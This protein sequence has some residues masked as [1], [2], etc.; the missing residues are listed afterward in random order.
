MIAY[1]ILA[2]QSAEQVM[3]LIGSIYRPGDVYAVHMDAKASPAE[4]AKLA[5]LCRQKPNIY[6]FKSRACAWGSF[7]LVRVVLD[8][9]QSLL[10]LT[11]NWSHFVLLSEQHYPLRPAP[12]IASALKRDVSYLNTSRH[13]D[14]SQGGQNDIGHR[15]KRVYHELEGVGSFGA[16]PRD[17]DL[18]HIYHASQWSV[19]SRFAAGFLVSSFRENRKSWADLE[20]SLLPDEI[21]FPTI[22]MNASDD[23]R[24]EVSGEC[25]T[26]V[27]WPH[28]TDNPDLIACTKTFEEGKKTSCLFIRKRPS[29]LS[30][31]TEF[32]IKGPETIHTNIEIVPPPDTSNYKALVPQLKQEIKFRLDHLDIMDY[33]GQ[34]YTARVQLKLRCRNWDWRVNVMVISHDGQKFRIILLAGPENNDLAEKQI[35]QYIAH[36]LKV[37]LVDIQGYY[38]VD[39][40][41][42]FDDLV[43]LSSDPQREDFDR[44]IEAICPYLI[45]GE[46]VNQ[47]LIGSERAASSI[48]KPLLPAKTAP[49]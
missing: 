15:F 46:N 35:G 34:R 6:F 38:H 10:D 40:G 47:A 33:F 8:C 18:S 25:L 11:E 29:A 48:E 37:R 12:E 39:L 22:L 31:F 32:V 21:A 14:F 3:Q 36:V 44:L 9:M 41:R 49:S 19:L 30:D 28:R 4:I 7:S 17:L 16:E 42:E 23:V 45:A 27:A 43:H 26:Y 5:A 2:M 20:T 13:V 1:L 24:G